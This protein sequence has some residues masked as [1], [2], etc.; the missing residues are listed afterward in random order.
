MFE[1]LIA[2]TAIKKIVCAKSEVGLFFLRE[3]LSLDPLVRQGSLVSEPQGSTVSV[4]SALGL[5]MGVSMICLFTW[6]QKIEMGS[7]FLQGKHFPN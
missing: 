6:V 7:P 1:A 2:L 3:G 4:S 5:Q